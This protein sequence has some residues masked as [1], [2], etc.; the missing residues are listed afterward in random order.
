M[1][2]IASSDTFNALAV[3]YRFTVGKD[4]PASSARRVCD[5]PSIAMHVA[6]QYDENR[7]TITCAGESTK[8]APTTADCSKTTR[9]RSAISWRPR[10]HVQGR[11]GHRVASRPD[12]VGRRQCL[13]HPPRFP[14]PALHAPAH[15]PRRQPCR[16]AECR[17]R[18]GDPR[19]HRGLQGQVTRIVQM[20][21][22]E[23]LD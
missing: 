6:A 10:L 20:F 21:G 16:A 17:C 5:Q 22:R 12:R 7:T 4:N 13:R 1:A 9:A 3:S 15:R 18:A 19:P 8:V 23:V 2:A 14:A 11:Y